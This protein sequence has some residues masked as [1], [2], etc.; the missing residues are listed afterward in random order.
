MAGEK[1]P[2]R[3]HTARE[4]ASSLKLELENRSKDDID[5]VKRNQQLATQMKIKRAPS[6][7]MLKNLQDKTTKDL[8]TYLSQKNGKVPQ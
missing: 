7:E 3:P 2:I 5:F 8:D 6:V 1:K 4:S